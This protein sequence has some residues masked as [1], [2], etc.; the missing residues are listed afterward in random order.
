MGERSAGVQY[1]KSS[2][3]ALSVGDSERVGWRLRIERERERERELYPRDTSQVKFPFFK[4]MV[5]RPGFG[6]SL[7]RFSLRCRRLQDMSI[8]DEY[9]GLRCSWLG[10]EILHSFGQQKALKR[11]TLLFQRRLLDRLAHLLRL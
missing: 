10:G 9:G 4:R 5:Q 11:A 2:A 8:V 7:R 3:K 1:R 6:V